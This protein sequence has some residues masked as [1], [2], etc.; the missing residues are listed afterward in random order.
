MIKLNITNEICCSNKN[1]IK[2]L[3]QKQKSQC[4]NVEQDSKNTREIIVDL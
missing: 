1:M 3:I 2:S 4:E